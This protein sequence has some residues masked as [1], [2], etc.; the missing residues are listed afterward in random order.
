MDEV[1]AWRNVVEVEA[2]EETRQK[3]NVKKEKV[4]VKKKKKKGSI[5][6][7]NVGCADPREEFELLYIVYQE[8]SERKP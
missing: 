5:R 3:T 8:D 7:R 2:M 4:S 1:E 6:S